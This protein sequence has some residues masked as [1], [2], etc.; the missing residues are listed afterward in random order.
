MNFLADLL[1]T[2]FDRRYRSLF[3]SAN[4]SRTIEECCDDLLNTSGE[5]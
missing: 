2:V 1:T 5:A 3:G 4:D